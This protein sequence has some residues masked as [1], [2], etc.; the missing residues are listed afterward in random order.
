MIPLR[1]RILDIA[2]T[3]LTA[4]L[5]L[6]L[7]AI[8]ALA[9]LAI[10]GLPIFYISTRR[11]HGT[12]S[13]RVFKFRTMVKGADAVAN[14]DTIA[15]GDVRFLN[16]A[17]DSP[18]YTSLG[19]LLEQGFNELPQLFHVIVGEMSLVGSR[20]LP[21][22]VIKALGEKYPFAQ[23]R[24]LTPAG[25]TGPVQLIGRHRLSDDR[26]LMLEAKY[27]RACLDSYSAL[28]D[29]AILTYTFLIVLRMIKPLSEEKMERLLA[30][31]SRSNPV[32]E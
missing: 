21:E 1:K 15:I 5:W 10:D 27:C 11:V 28:T 7:L 32:R 24:F 6:P 14:R 18:L 29:L 3:L 25:M 17:A 26:R 16:L 31:H 4:P 22:N 2:L 12:R 23:D 13:A 8:I 9:V 30:R 20:P 19:R